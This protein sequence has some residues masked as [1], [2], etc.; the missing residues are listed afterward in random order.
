[1]IAREL[2]IRLRVVSSSAWRNYFIV[3]ICM[4]ISSVYELLE[5]AT[6]L[7]L[8]EQSDA[9]LG[10]QGDPWDTQMDMFLALVGAVAALT[11]LARLHDSQLRR[12]RS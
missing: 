3:S 12:L 2:L 4:A 7:V 10:T 9:F 6:A 5:W 8:G 1:M 11:F